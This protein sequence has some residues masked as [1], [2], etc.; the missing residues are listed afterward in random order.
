MS[1][2]GKAILA[3]AAVTAGLLL[4]AAQK[5]DQ[6]EVALRAAID[7]ELIDGDLKA[8]IEMYKKVLARPGGNRAVAAKAL[9]H[10]GQC[11]EKL[12]NAEAR[13][14]YEQLLREYPDQGEL[15]AQARTRLAALG[16]AGGLSYPPAITVRKVWEGREGETPGSPSAD[17]RYF[18]FGHM[19]TGDIAVRDLV[20]GEQRRLTHEGTWDDPMQWGWA[21]LISPDSKQVA[22]SW[23]APKE[24]PELRVVG[25]DGGKSRTV[26][27]GNQEMAEIYPQAWSPDR[28]QIL[29]ILQKKDQSNQIGFVSVADGSIRILK[30]LP[31]RTKAS[32]VTRS[33]S[34]SLSPDGRNIVYD[35]LSREDC[36]EHDIFLLSTDGSPGAPLIQHPSDDKRPAWTPDGK[37]VLFASDRTGS[38]GF[39]AIAVA[40]G[41]PQ[42]PPELVKAD[43]GAIRWLTGVT[44]QG[45]CFYTTNAGME[46]VHIAEID[47]ETGKLLGP[48]DPAAGRFVGSSM[49]PSWSPDGEHLAYLAQRGSNV[50][51]QPGGLATVIRSLR[52]GEERELTTNLNQMLGPVRWFPDGR[53]LLVGA[54]EGTYR[55]SDAAVYRVDVQTDAVSLVTRVGRDVGLPYLAQNGG[56]ILYFQFRRDGPNGLAIMV[57]QIDTGQA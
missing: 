26:L 38:W 25:F 32:S 7:K 5:Q 35:F 47:P 40:D 24:I 14:S 18:T 57:H 39:W 10:I 45:A 23:Y 48:P 34:A 33:I 15:A 9:L 12:G 56:A 17:G 52:T 4:A 11:Q 46:D 42:G 19:A 31:P 1:N 16:K 50:L 3:L 41:K 6:A 27:R 37:K 28:K 36:K 2:Q 8:A 20:T 49:A 44:R 21:G 29:A 22:Y 54:W 51:Y 53:S 55:D 43:I 13:K 30:S